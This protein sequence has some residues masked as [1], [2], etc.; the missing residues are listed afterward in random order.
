MA[1]KRAKDRG[2]HLVQLTTSK[3]RDRAIDF[4]DELGFKATHDGMKLYL[5]PW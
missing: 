4:Y 3:E 1:I 2:C 5:K